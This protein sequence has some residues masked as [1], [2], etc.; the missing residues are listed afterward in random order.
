MEYVTHIIVLIVGI[1]IGYKLHRWLM[2]HRFKMFC[3]TG[4][5]KV[6]PIKDKGEGPFSS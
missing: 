5:L 2:C 1:V 3:L 4:Q 6:K